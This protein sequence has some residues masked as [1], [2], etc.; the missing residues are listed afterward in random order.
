MHHFQERK[1]IQ[2]DA[3]TK[4]Y[5]VYGAIV[6]QN[7]KEK[8]GTRVFVWKVQGNK[9]Q[10]EE[11]KTGY[12]CKNDRFSPEGARSRTALVIHSRSPAAKAE[13]TR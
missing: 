1:G 3:R 11:V 12:F 8:V 10:E 2:K 5:K 4:P 7:L 13:G 9:T 6:M